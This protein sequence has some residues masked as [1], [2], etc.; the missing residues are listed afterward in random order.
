[1]IPNTLYHYRAVS[2]DKAGNLAIS[3]DI[4]VQIPPDITA[5][6][7]TRTAAGFI[8]DQYAYFTW[9]TNEPADTQAEYGLTTSY[10]SITPL[11]PEMITSHASGVLG[12]APRATY[13]YPL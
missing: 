5:P 12:L 1:M 13:H 6:V 4:T 7:L 11:L 8:T 10:G 3:P 9:A 2:R